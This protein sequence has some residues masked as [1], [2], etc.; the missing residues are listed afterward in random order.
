MVKRLAY[1]CE[2]C[3]SPI[4][5]DKAAARYQRAYGEKAVRGWGE[6]HCGQLI[7]RLDMDKAFVDKAQATSM[8]NKVGSD[9]M[10]KALERARKR[11]TDK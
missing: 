1:K 9:L 11:K 5:P 4:N 6:C 3:G 8:T 2:R 7:S 10:R